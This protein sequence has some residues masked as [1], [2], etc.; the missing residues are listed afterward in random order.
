MFLRYKSLVTTSP[1]T[2]HISELPAVDFRRTQL[3][4][5]PPGLANRIWTGVFII[6]EGIADWLSS[7]IIGQFLEIGKTQT[8][9]RVIITYKSVK[10]PR[11]QF[12]S[13]LNH[14]AKSGSRDESVV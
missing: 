7:A 5:V 8:A 10:F 13:V 9:L 11:H 4:L 2:C 6:C 3:L 14:R 12:L 1:L